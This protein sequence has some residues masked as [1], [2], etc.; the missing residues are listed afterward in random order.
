MGSNSSKNVI[1]MTMKASMDV[2]NDVSNSCGGKVSNINE[3][4]FEGNEGPIVVSNT[5]Q[6]NMMTFDA[7]C[8]QS[9]STKA[10][11]N[12]KME[13][14]FSQLAETMKQNMSLNLSKA[15]S[16]NL[17]KLMTQ[18]SQRISNNITQECGPQVANTNRQTFRN[19]K[20]GIT[21]NMVSQK[22]LVSG[23]ARCTQ[24]S[25]TD[26]D[27]VNE[28]QNIVDQKASTKEENAAMWCG[29]M[30]LGFF[31]VTGKSS[32]DIVTNP[33]VWMGGMALSL[34]VGTGYLIQKGL[35][36]R[37]AAAAQSN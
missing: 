7:A 6:E 30:V 5:A 21:V 27:L 2:I 36:N 35:E 23:I 29:I 34:L 11:V 19:N 13:A 14:K 10:N 25:V 15:E 33:N 28:I 18:L 22:N 20:S 16:E 1:D 32:V 31:L 26:S 17:S 3:F 12:N 24:Q 8:L 9:A 37:D 4:T